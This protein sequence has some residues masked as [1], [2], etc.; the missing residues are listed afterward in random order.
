MNLSQILCDPQIGALP[1]KREGSI[2]FRDYIQ[3]L[4]NNY[5]QAIAEMQDDRPIAQEVQSRLNEIK[6]IASGV[7]R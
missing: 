6:M 3:H 1:R 4:S 7:G 5:V 2:D